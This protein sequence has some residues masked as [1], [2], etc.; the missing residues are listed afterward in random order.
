M[1]CP[2]RSRAALP[3]NN[4]TNMEVSTRYLFFKF[5]LFVFHCT[6]E[7]RLTVTSLLRTLFF[8]CLAKTAIHFLAKNTVVNTAN[9]FWLNGGR[10]V[11]GFHCIDCLL[12]LIAPIITFQKKNE[13]NYYPRPSTLDPRPLTKRYSKH[14]HIR[15]NGLTTPGLANKAPFL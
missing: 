13:K 15:T 4:K 7:P 3:T 12:L 14:P 2:A 8:S 11:T 1:G 9:I 5:F 10:T 6:V